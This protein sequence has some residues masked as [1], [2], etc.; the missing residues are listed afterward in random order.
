MALTV[1]LTTNPRNAE[2]IAQ[3]DQHRQLLERAFKFND[4][5]LFKVCRN[6][7]QFYPPCLE[8]LE[9]YMDRYIE[10]AQRSDDHT[11]LLL[12]LLGTMVYIPTDKW[13]EKI[14]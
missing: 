7:A 1:N 4:T 14:E 2:L 10:L 6:I 5:L 8:T 11:D 9:E 12:E 13:A 3:E